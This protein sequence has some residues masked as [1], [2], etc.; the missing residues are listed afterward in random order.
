MPTADAAGPIA[1]A[2]IDANFYTV[3]VTADSTGRP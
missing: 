1:R 2:I 3:R